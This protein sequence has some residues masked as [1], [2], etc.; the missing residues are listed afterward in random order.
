MRELGGDVAVRI[1]DM[2]PQVRVLSLVLRQR[3]L[4]LID[5]QQLF[6]VGRL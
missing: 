5:L 2:L 6:A 3:L 4:Q 1:R